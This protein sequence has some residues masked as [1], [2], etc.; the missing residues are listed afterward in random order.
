[1]SW[2]KNASVCLYASFPFSTSSCSFATVDC[3][4]DANASRFVLDSSM[5]ARSS[6]FTPPL[7]SSISVCFN[8]SVTDFNCRLRSSSSCRMPSKL[9]CVAGS[10]SGSSS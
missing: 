5:S 9:S 3:A 6:S 7:F 8:S 1:M 4:F 2:Q 10:R